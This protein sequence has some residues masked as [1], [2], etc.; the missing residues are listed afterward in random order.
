MSEILT[1][2]RRHNVP[3]VIGLKLEIFVYRTGSSLPRLPSPLRLF[4]L[5]PALEVFGSGLNLAAN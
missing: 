4:E 3:E 5:V 2:E 1:S